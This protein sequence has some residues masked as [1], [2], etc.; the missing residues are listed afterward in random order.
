MFSRKI[1]ISRS[2]EDSAGEAGCIDSACSE[3]W[4]QWC[5]RAAWKEGCSRCGIH[6]FSADGQVVIGLLISRQWKNGALHR[7][8]CGHV[9]PN[10]GTAERSPAPKCLRA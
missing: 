3:G 6:V 9:T 1:V 7:K 4:D 5:A 10:L 2:P 8:N